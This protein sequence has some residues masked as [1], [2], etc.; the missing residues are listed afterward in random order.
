MVLEAGEGSVN[1]S[2]FNAI[3]DKLRLGGSLAGKSI[4]FVTE[5]GS[6]LVK[7]GDDLLA[8]IKDVVTGVQKALVWADIPLYRYEVV[9]LPKCGGRDPNR[10][11]CLSAEGDRDNLN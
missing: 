6:T 2:G 11:P 10:N 9:D 7:A 3:A 8:T 4:S 5:L 1:V